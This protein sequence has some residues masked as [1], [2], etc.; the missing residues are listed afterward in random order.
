MAE[1]IELAVVTMRL[2]AL[3]T[4]LVAAAAARYVVLSRGAPGCRNIDLCAAAGDPSRLLIIEKWAAVDDATA[5]L[6]A[7]ETVEFAEACRG[8]LMAAPTIELW[9]GV[10][11]HDLA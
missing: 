3:D 1:E 10:S 2:H 8:S 9:D 4:P 11:A 6:G 5:H 7:P